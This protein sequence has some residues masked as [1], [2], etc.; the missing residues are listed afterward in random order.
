MEG[1]EVVE[2]VD[3]EGGAFMS[4]EDASKTYSDLFYHVERATA[5]FSESL[6]PKL[7]T[8]F[9]VRWICSDTAIII[10]ATIGAWNKGY[11]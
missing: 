10:T 2:L 11:P 4:S 5:V 1:W 8:Q 3:G 9:L 7:C 6:F